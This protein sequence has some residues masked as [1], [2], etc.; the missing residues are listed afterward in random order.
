MFC[1]ILCIYSAAISISSQ[2]IYKQYMFCLYIPKCHK[3]VPV[4][5]ITYTYT[6]IIH[7]CMHVF[8]QYLAHK[9][10]HT[11]MHYTCTIVYMYLIIN[12]QIHINMWHMFNDNWHCQH[13]EYIL[14]V[15]HETNMHG[16]VHVLH[17][18]SIHTRHA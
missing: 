13:V 18:L 8:G 16:S 4:Y 3:H 11:Y 12:K 9:Y 5:V 6:C 1:H 14:H 10:T 2:D 17:V 15:T 7:T